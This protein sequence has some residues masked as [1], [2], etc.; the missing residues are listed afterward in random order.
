MKVL[1]DECMPSPIAKLLIGHIC[2]TTQSQGWKGLKN[3]RLLALAN[4]NFDVFV[5]ADRSLQ[6]EQNLSGFEIAILQVST[7]HVGRLQQAQGLIQSSL[8]Q[9]RPGQVLRVEIP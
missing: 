7:N 1:L 4:Q 5:T 6:Y 9:I 8:E 2:A 3:G